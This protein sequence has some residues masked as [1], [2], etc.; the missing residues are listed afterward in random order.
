MTTTTMMSVLTANQDPLPIFIA[1]IG[2]ND[3]SCGACPAL[4]LSSHLSFPPAGKLDA[5]L[6]VTP[7]QHADA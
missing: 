1:T 4:H 7:L 2:E 6:K 3:S 5:R